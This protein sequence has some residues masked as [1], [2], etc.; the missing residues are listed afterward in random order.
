MVTGRDRHLGTVLCYQRDLGAS[1]GS[2][3]SKMRQVTVKVWLLIRMVRKAAPPHLFV[4]VK[5]RL[6]LAQ[7]LKLT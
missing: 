7:V 4:C 1:V 5:S 3:P 6:S 2:R